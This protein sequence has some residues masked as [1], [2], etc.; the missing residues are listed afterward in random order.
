MKKLV[1]AIAFASAAAFAAAGA[2]TGSV[3]VEIPRG[4]KVDSIIKA[5]KAE[6]K[7]DSSQLA[8]AGKRDS[9]KFDVD[10]AKLPDSV[11]TAIK[12]HRVEIEARVAEFQKLKGDAIKIKLDSLSSEHKAHRDSVITKL[13]EAVQAKIKANIAEIDARRAELKTRI[14]ADRAELKARIEAAKAAKAAAAATTTTP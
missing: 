10:V 8:N 2:D 13:P 14:E 7:K 12:A 9:V 6:W 5:E 4:V 1:I 11:K 3:K